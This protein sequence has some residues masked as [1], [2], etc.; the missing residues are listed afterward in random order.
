M[1]EEKKGERARYDD[2]TATHDKE[3]IQP[4]LFHVDSTTGSASVFSQVV[5]VTG[6][7]IVIELAGRRGWVIDG[8]VASEG[9]V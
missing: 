7:R 6:L 9:G 4:C 2:D 8:G 1:P 5:P 3:E